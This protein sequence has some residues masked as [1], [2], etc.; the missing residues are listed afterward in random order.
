MIIEVA[1]EALRRQIGRATQFINANGM[2]DIAIFE[3]AALQE[4]IDALLAR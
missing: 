1:G 4:E 3:D 2:I